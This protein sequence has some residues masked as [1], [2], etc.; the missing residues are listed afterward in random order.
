MTIHKKNC[1]ARGSERHH[2]VRQGKTGG[3]GGVR[4]ILQT[5]G[6]E[7]SGQKYKSE[8]DTRED[9]SFT[10]I[11]SQTT[12]DLIDSIVEEGLV[13]L[14]RRLLVP[15]LVLLWLVLWLLLELGVH[16]HR[17]HCCRQGNEL[18]NHTGATMTA[19]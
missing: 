16:S 17:L 2:H 19:W 3:G 10:I 5:D 6:S 14:L 4:R 11:E 13:L 1:V 12:A 18:E 9:V 8:K 7:W 15:V